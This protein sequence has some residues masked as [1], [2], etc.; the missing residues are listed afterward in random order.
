MNRLAR[1]LSTLALFIAVSLPAIL[2][3]VVSCMSASHVQQMVLTTGYPH[4]RHR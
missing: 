1:F 2:F 4:R 3:V